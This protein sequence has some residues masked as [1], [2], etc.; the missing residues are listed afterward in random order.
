M[1]ICV[2]PMDPNND[3]NNDAPTQL[4]EERGTAVEVPVGCLDR[5]PCCGVAE[6]MAA[7]RVP[8]LS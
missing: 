2:V 8:G 7:A 6:V 5:A 4:P 3:A 1:G